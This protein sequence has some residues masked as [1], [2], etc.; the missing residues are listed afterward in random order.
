MRTAL[1]SLLFSCSWRYV[2]FCHVKKLYLL[3][4]DAIEYMALLAAYKSSK[5][6]SRIHPFL[7]MVLQYFDPG[8]VLYLFES[9]AGYGLISLRIVA[10][11][12]FIYS[13][14]FT[15]KHYPEKATFYYPF[16]LVGTLWLVHL[17]KW[18]CFTV[19]CHGIKI[20]ISFIIIFLF[21][22]F[23]MYTMIP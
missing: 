23:I 3:T 5:Q 18:L 8:E 1:L 4:S 6:C 16:N 10:W 13:T 19:S 15:L 2:A 22:W 12:M 11:W 20:V 14:I 9:P 17:S 7:L 21:Y